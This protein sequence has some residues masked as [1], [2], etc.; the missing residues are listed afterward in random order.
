MNVEK[1]TEFFMKIA[2]ERAG[3]SAVLLTYLGDK[4]G[5]WSAMAG[6]GPV[7]SAEL[8]ARTGLA[9]RYLREWLAGQAV[10][11]H[12]TYDAATGRF[13]LPAEHAAVL[14]DES[15]LAFQGGGLEGAAAQWMAADKIADAFRTG[16]GVAWHDHDPRMFSA[17]ARFFGPLY[18]SSV[19]DQWL[20]A[21]DG[22]VDRLRD[23]AHVLDVG[24]GH[25]TSTI[26]MAQAFP[27]CQFLG[28]DY[29]EESVLA[30][31]EAAAKAG[32]DDRVEFVVAEADAYPA[33]EWDLIC[34][35]DALHDMGDPVGAAAGARAS[36]AP[37]GAVMLIEP[38]A[39]DRLEDSIG[40]PVALAYYTA[41]TM[42]CV[43]NSLAQ[44]GTALG[45]QAGP[46]QLTEVL[47]AAGFGTVRRALETEYNL[48]LEARA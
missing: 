36:L 9:E 41:S 12:V 26:L 17:T 33:G 40:S 22:V 42:V 7:D 14:A 4:L 43:P 38:F 34:F 35:F 10:A 5:I 23:G 44:H 27:Q 24:C 37:G 39:A 15:S 20:P 16:A 45:A 28:V 46:E 3:A 25:G 29:H 47:K 6:A 30:A 21:L 31:R 11:G 2:D 18:R 48:V 13:E 1:V 19:V 32:V 8:A